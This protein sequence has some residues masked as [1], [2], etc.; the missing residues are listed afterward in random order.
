MRYEIENSRQEDGR[1]GWTCWIRNSTI[2]KVGRGSTPEEALADFRNQMDRPR[3]LIYSDLTFN[4]PCILK[5][6]N[7]EVHSISSLYFCVEGTWAWACGVDKRMKKL[8]ISTFSSWEVLW[9]GSV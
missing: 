3:K 9:D 6:P 4:R 1:A 7:G 8:S 2:S 5:S